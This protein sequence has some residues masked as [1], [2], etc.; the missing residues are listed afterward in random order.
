MLGARCLLAGQAGLMPNV[1][2]GDDTRIAAKSGV[3]RS[4]PG[5]GAL[6]GYVAKEHA[7]ALRELIELRKLPELAA[8][9]R[10]L[11]QQRS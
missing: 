2:V 9:I 1:E 4:F 6:S 10:K 5:G 8:R 3:A 11:E 7:A